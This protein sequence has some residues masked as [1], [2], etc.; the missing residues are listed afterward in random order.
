MTKIVRTKSRALG[1][2]TSKEKSLM[3]QHARLWIARAMRTKTI[4][5]DKIT[6]AINGLY[7]AAG[8]KKPRIVIVQSPLV[9][10]FAYGASAAIWNS[11]KNRRSATDS[12]TVSATRSATD[13]A[14][15]GAA[16]ACFDLAGE[17]G[18]SYSCKWHSAYQGGN[19]WAGYDCY[20]TACRDILGLELKEHDAYQYW[21]CLLY[22]SPSPRDKRQS[23]MPSS[24]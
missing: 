8:L 9:M 14:T 3:D 4:E 11:R 17:L 18:L 10:A 15:D 7:K 1:G 21:D 13:S 20:L 23:R 12:A 22:T 19:M 6:P 2:I 16:I 24:A 5:P